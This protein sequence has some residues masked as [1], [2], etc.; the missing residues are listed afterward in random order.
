MPTS[1]TNLGEVDRYALRGGTRT[2]FRIEDLVGLAAL[3]HAVSDKR[4]VV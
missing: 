2:L 4:R 3:L 1:W